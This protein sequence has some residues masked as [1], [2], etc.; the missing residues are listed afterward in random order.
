MEIICSCG[1]TFDFGEPDDI[2]NSGKVEGF[3][4]STMSDTDGNEYLTL[5]CLRC[6]KTICLS[7]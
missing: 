5:C 4:F 6:D 1:N 7:E 3:E 2:N